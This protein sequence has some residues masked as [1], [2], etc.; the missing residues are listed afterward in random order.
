MFSFFVRVVFAAL[1]ITGSGITSLNA[2]TEVRIYAEFPRVVDKQSRYVVYL[3]GAIVEGDEERP[4]HPEFG[5]YE[6][7]QIA[8][9]LFRNG[10]FNLIAHHREKQAD[11]NAYVDRL[12][13]WIRT[14]VREGVSPSRITVVGFSRGSYLAAALGARVQDLSI[15]TALLAACIDGKVGGDPAPK[16][17]GNVLSIYEASDVA[18]SCKDVIGG[19]GRAKSFSEVEIST[20][21]KHGAFYTPMPQWLDPL[22]AWIRD[23]NR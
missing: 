8:Q 16:L 2:E 7:P 23:T 22:K 14:L 18:K 4:V 19:E 21:R 9:D 17:P 6:F 15:N 1:L 11:F 5:T 20:G 12:E 3:H 13:E 10:G